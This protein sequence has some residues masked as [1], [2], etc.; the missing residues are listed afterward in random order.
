MTAPLSPSE[1]GRALAARRAF[2][3]RAAKCARCGAEFQKRGRGLYCS[4]SCR[5]LSSRAKR[6]ARKA[7]Q[8]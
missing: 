6:K 2:P 1:L 7:A 4:Q 5:E 3:A 8:D